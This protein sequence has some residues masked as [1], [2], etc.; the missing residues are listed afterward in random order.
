MCVSLKNNR[1]KIKNCFIVVLNAYINNVEV[2]KYHTNPENEATSE[3]RSFNSLTV[4]PVFVGKAFQQWL[5]SFQCFL[6]FIAI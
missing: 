3:I 4:A 2:M 5:R 1:C 6:I